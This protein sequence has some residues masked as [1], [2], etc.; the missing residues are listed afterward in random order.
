MGTVF[1]RWARPIVWTGLK[2]L[3]T[4]MG[5]GGPERKRVGD[6]NKTLRLSG[7]T[8]PGEKI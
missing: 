4:L 3:S 1:A 2:A 6:N 5:S 7:N 8:A